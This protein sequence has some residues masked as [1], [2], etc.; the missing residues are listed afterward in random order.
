MRSVNL[1][2][3]PTSDSGWERD[4]VLNGTQ[5]STYLLPNEYGTGGSSTLGIKGASS[6]VSKNGKSS[7]GRGDSGV[8]E[9][10]AKEKDSKDSEG[11]EGRE[12][13]EHERDIEQGE[14]DKARVHDAGVKEEKDDGMDLAAEKDKING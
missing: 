13:G 8:G 12:Q 11:K 6:S 2:A 9:G 4:G 7:A 14:G 1:T 5:K 3:A 10:V